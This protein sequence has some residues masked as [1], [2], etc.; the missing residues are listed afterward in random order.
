MKKRKKHTPE[1]IVAKLR[2][3]YV[4]MNHSFANGFWNSF[5]SDRDSAIAALHSCF[6]QR[7]LEP[8]TNACIKIGVRKD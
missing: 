5:E 4:L 7:G 1:Q 6:V 2:D 3:A 8:A